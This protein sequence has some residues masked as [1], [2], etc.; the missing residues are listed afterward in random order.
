MISQ[1]ECLGLFDVYDQGIYVC[2]DHPD[3]VAALRFAEIVAREECQE[4]F[5]TE[6]WNC[7]SFSILK[8]PNIT[9]KG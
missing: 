1:E 5:Q 9:K 8:A 7:S 2:R 6:R 3:L 4:A